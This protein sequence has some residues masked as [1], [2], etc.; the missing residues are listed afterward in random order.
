MS[1]R[2]VRVHRLEIIYPEGSREPGWRPD[3]WDSYLRSLP[4]LKRRRLRKAGF[5]W[6]RERMFLSSS[7]AY[8]RAALLRAFGADVEVLRSD[9]VTWPAHWSWE[10]EAYRAA[11]GW[12]RTF[13]CSGLSVLSDEDEADLVEIWQQVGLLPGREGAGL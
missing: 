1:G 4:V 11:P 7:S 2:N 5:S 8:Q 6:P 12:H 3:S 10:D 9:P 13:D